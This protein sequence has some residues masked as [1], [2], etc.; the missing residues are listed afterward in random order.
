MDPTALDQ[1]FRTEYRRMVRDPAWRYYSALSCAR[2]GRI[3]PTSEDDYVARRFA[4]L[5]RWNKAV[6]P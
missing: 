2:R 6:G 3:G 1:Q 5:E 4:E